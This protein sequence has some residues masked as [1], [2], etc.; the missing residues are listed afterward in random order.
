MPDTQLYDTGG[1]GTQTPKSITTPL[2]STSNQSF[3]PVIEPV[4]R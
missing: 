1:G 2:A 4:A 3:P